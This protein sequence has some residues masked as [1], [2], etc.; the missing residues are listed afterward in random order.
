MNRKPQRRKNFTLIELLVVIAIIAILAA[1]LL[2]TLNRSRNVAKQMSCGNILKQFGLASK[3]YE[4]DFNDWCIPMNYVAGA[5]NIRWA[6]VLRPYMNQQPTDALSFYYRRDLI[7]PLATYAL[8]HFNSSGVTNISQSY[9]M[10]RE[11]LPASTEPYRGIRNTRVRN[12]SMK[13]LIGDA[14][15]WLVS[16]LRVDIAN[17]LKYGENPPTSTSDNNII[18]YRHFRKA[19]IVFY[20]GHVGAAQWHE[21]A[22]S[23]TYWNP[24]KP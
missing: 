22:D 24:T 5:T 3:M 10:N 6:Y 15:D 9:G 21:I 1:M 13:L 19:G 17:Y 7:C 11:G 16:Y 18:A 14:T 12:G 2:P 4:N 20:D 23:N 8:N